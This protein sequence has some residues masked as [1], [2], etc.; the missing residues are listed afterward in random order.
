VGD[1]PEVPGGASKGNSTDSFMGPIGERGSVLDVSSGWPFAL[2]VSPFAVGA[3]L[4]L[5][6]GRR[7]EDTRDLVSF[8]SMCRDREGDR[9]S[10]GGRDD[11]GE[12]LESLSVS[13]SRSVPFA[14]P[15]IAEA[16]IYVRP[17]TTQCGNA[18]KNAAKTAGPR[19]VIFW[20]P[21]D[22]QLRLDA[23]LEGW[24]RRI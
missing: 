14:V 19:G 10:L 12:T 4:T 7:G 1:G 18:A 15:S 24:F 23:M 20:S 16:M 13:R 17:S 8:E 11:V 5:C 22:S 6:F 3:S 9:S 2:D 21:V